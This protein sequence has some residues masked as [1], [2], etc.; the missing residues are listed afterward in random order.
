MLI[1]CLLS[2]SIY[3]G[4]SLSRISSIGINIHSGFI[5]PHS[6]SIKEISYS[7]PRIV[8]V[9]YSFLH[10]KE[11]SWQ[12]CQCFSKVGMSYYFVDFDNPKIIGFANGLIFFVEPFFN[13]FKKFHFSYRL[14][15]GPVYLNQP[16][17]S[18]TNPLNHFYSTYW[19]YL[20]IAQLNIN[21]HFNSQWAI[22]LSGNYNHISNSGVKRP[23]KGI[24]FPTVSFGIQYF[25]Q[26]LIVPQYFRSTEN[27]KTQ[28]LWHYN[29]AVFGTGKTKT[30]S[31]DK[32]Y[33]VYGLYIDVGRKV[34]RINLFSTGIE[35][36]AN[37][38][39]KALIEDKDMDVSHYRLST[40]IGHNLLIGRFTF[41]QFVGF[42]VF[43]PY[44]S[45]DRLYQR[46]ALTYQINRLFFAGINLKAHRHVADFMDVR[47]GVRL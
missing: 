11:K 38:A 30:M 7:K 41:S 29:L 45:M 36:E 16:Y 13:Q 10:R 21:Y 15:G 25:T 44:K 26:P 31:Q 18:I 19:N 9:D 33:P 34:S 47:L 39:H 27:W 40:V 12:Y 6:E 35:V 46:Y 1:L 28:S 43:D 4:D 14:A 22:K 2:F 8:Q 3:A 5:I 17:H 23:N 42:Y 32:K 20:I 24:N 37:L